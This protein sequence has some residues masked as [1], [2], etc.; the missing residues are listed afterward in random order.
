MICLTYILLQFWRHWRDETPFNTLDEKLKESYSEIEVIKCIQ[1]GLLCVQEDPNARPTM[2]SIV[3]YLNN[4]S[5]E[6]P[7]PPPSS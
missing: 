1:I 6:L 5:I 4:H 3:S 7:T 2:M